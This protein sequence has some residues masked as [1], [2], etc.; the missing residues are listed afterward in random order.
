MV[1]EGQDGFDLSSGGSVHEGCGNDC[2]VSGFKEGFA[3]G[4]GVGDADAVVLYQ[5]RGEGSDGGAA[6]RAGEGQGVASGEGEEGAREKGWQFLSW[7]GARSAK[8][9]MRFGLEL[10]CSSEVLF[11]VGLEVLEINSQL[12]AFLV[13]MASLQAQCFCGLGDV[14]I[15]KLQLGEDL[16]FFKR[17]HPNS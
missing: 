5:S 2:A 14:A 6:D 7:P 13:E 10:F 16:G 9:E 15:V 11:F 4:A 17:L 1:G 8:P 12:L 3:E